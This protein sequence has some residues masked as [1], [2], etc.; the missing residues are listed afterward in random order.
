[1]GAVFSRTLKNLLTLCQ[2]PF[3]I[4]EPLVNNTVYAIVTV[5]GMCYNKFK[6]KK[7]MQ[8][9][10]DRIWELYLDYNK[11]AANQ[12]ASATLVLATI[13]YE[14]MIQPIKGEESAKPPAKRR[15]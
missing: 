9:T 7:I 11:K 1:M 5:N 14:R 4:F 13:L 3:T 10:T 15:K 12:Q 2:I 6:D 8:Q